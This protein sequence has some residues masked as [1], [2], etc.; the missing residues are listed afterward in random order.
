LVNYEDY[1]TV[2]ENKRK[3][4]E[5]WPYLSLTNPIY[6]ADKVTGTINFGGKLLE[7]GFIKTGGVIKGGIQKATNYLE[8]KI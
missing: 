7:K 6:E 8:S 3:L 5:H 2:E 1:I 4:E